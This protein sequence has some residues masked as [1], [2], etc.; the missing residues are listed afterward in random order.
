[1]E[2][3]CQKL[4]QN[5]KAYAAKFG[6]DISQIPEERI[7][8]AYISKYYNIR[9]CERYL[10][11]DSSIRSS[12]MTLKTVTSSEN[13]PTKASLLGSSVKYEPSISSASRKITGDSG[14]GVLIESNGRSY[15]SHADKPRVSEISKRSNYTL[16]SAPNQIINQDSM[17]N[18][19]RYLNS[20]NSAIKKN[21][22]L[23]GS[24][25]AHRFPNNS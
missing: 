9:E 13:R 8:E 24:P 2:D 19:I 14:V 12:D 21:R 16:P 15:L 4:V 7:F 6:R 20:R 22:S 23:L 18:D 25:L 3:V 11:G 17:N 1:M 5:A 10:F